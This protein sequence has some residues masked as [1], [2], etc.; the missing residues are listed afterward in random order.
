MAGVAGRFFLLLTIYVLSL[1]LGTVTIAEISNDKGD[2]NMEFPSFEPVPK[3]P[4]IED[5]GVAVTL[6]VAEFKVG[7]PVPMFGSYVIDGEFM[8]KCNDEPDTWIFL[9]VIRRDKPGVWSKPVL[10]KPNLAPVPSQED[11]AP[12]PTVRSGGYFNLD[13]RGH[14]SLPDEPGSYWLIVSMGNYITER[15]SFEIRE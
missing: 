3:S 10:E 6:D 11:E 2:T 14:M 15:I 13:L 4:E 8:Q 1:C 7:E 9:I 5:L 12:G